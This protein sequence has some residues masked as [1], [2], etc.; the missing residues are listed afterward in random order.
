VVVHP[1]ADMKVQGVGELTD[2]STYW[3][4]TYAECGHVQEFAR[5]GLDEPEDA[6]F[7]VWRHYGQCLTCARARPTAVEL[8]VEPEQFHL[9]LRLDELAVTIAALRFV[10]Q[11]ELAERLDSIRRQVSALHG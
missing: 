2:H 3:R 1:L 9:V 5:E 6:A 4:L 10:D 11:L 7:Y 8:N